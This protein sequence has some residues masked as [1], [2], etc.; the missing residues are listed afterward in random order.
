MV[1]KKGMK[2]DKKMKDIL[3]YDQENSRNFMVIRRRFQ[4]II[5]DYILGIMVNIGGNIIYQMIL[6]QLI[7][8]TMLYEVWELMLL[9]LLLLYV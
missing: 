7:I 3:L 8:Y 9:D 5:L 1:R 4:K 2:I 6:V